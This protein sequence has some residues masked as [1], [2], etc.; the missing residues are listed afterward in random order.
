M[1][2][3]DEAL[4]LV[5]AR[6]A[7]LPPVDRGIA[8]AL[9]ARL[10]APLVA[11]GAL[12]AHD[13]AAMDGW[14]IRAAL[15][16]DAS[17]ETPAWLEEG[18][19]AVPIATGDEIPE[20]ADS[21]VP[22]ELARREGSRVGVLLPPAPDAN[23][24]RRGE[25]VAVG[26]VLVPAGAKVDATV[27]L[28]AAALG[29][30]ILR[31][32]PRIRAAVLPVGA[33]VA[34]GRPDATGIAIHAAIEGLGASSTLLD[35]A[36]GGAAEVAARIS[37]GVR[38]VDLFVTVGAASVGRD[39]VVP[40]ALDSLGWT[41]IF[42]GVSVKPGK[43][44]GLWLHGAAAILVLP[45][46]PAAALACF[47]AIGRAICARLAGAPPQDAVHAV[48]ARSIERRRGKTGLLRGR[49]V[50]TPAGL[51]FSASPK[52]GPSQVSAVA[53]TN[54]LALIPPQVDMVSAG[55]SLRVL[56]LGEIFAEEAP[57]KAV[58]ICGLSGAGK[59][60]LVERL[61]GRLT[62]KGLRVATVKHD[63]H[64]FDA[65]PP[66]KDTARH[67]AAGAVATVL[68]GPSRTMQVQE[69]ALDLDEAIRRAARGADVVIVE[70]FKRDRSLP[71]IEVAARGRERIHS[72]PLLALVTDVLGATADAPVLGT[73][74]RDLD[75]LCRM[76]LE[77]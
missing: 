18:R 25:D 55:E 43:P 1:I 63:A 13:D 17:R 29:N 37:A 61:V 56:P 46:S 2:S 50:S 9:G 45:G 64:G 48:A 8:Q 30:E 42:H 71:K 77:I 35:H 39:D 49:L 75:E 19:E 15:A 76:V 53:D 59:T 33:H 34:S 31:I 16:K 60:W 52:Q 41:Q 74:E 4:A 22:L 23:I 3:F 67:R 6:V 12:P 7:P 21:V 5:A 62:A 54:A 10:A 44:V 40:T 28:A 58:A 65:E 27:A 47:D 51:R 14:A 20:G 24:R 70:G 26:T 57:P 66:G 69:R 73:S 72:A 11:S 36:A 38:D 68:V 32:H